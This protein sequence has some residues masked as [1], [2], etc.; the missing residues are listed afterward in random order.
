MT[1]MGLIYPGV[2]KKLA[3]ILAKEIGADVF[4][5]TGTL[6]GETAAWAAGHFKRV[7]SIEID[8]AL[9]QQARAL[10]RDRANVELLLGPSEHWLP[11]IVHTVSGP[12]LFWLDAHYSGPGTGGE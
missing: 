2:P 5:E 3:L 6:S 10:V 9:H 7:I 12:A 11:Q 1:G 4:I 8:E